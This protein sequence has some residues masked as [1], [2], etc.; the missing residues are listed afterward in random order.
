MSGGLPF[1][2]GLAFAGLASDLLGAADMI[3]TPLPLFQLLANRLKFVSPRSGHF[4]IA[5]PETSQGVDDDTRN[6]EPCIIFIVGRHHVPWRGFRTGGAQ[7]VLVDL[8]VLI[9]RSEGRRAG[10]EW[11]SRC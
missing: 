10:K 2:G 9:P 7:A 11:G 1:A 4:G 6:D 5:H 3:F 8:H